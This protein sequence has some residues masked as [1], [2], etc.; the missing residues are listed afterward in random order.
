MNT[1]LV[2]PSVGPACVGAAPHQRKA[3]PRLRRPDRSKGL[4]PV[5]LEQLLEPAHPARLVW[6]F[7]QGLD[8]GTLYDS[9]KS[10]EGHPGRAPA[11]PRLLVALWLFATYDG[12]GSA[13][14]LARLCDP[15]RDGSLPYLW[16]CGGL[17]LNYHTLSDFRVKHADLLDRLLTDGLAV[18]LKEEL[19]E[20]EETAQD[21]LRVRASAGSGSFRRR[22]TLEQCQQQAHR[23]VEQLRAELEQDPAG[24]SRRQQAAR[25]RAARER[26]ERLG[27]A[28]QELAEL[29]RHKQ[30]R[31]EE[32][33]P[34]SDRSGPH[35]A[36]ASTT[37]PQAR[38]LRMADGGYRPAY[39]VELNTTTAGGVIVGVG[40]SNR[41]SDGGCVVAMLE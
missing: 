15:H 41:G 6:D 13:R 34:E 40:V 11:E 26:Q 35:E 17:A 16:L 24:P 27:R 4:P 33:G 37:D 39:N 10:V 9:I 29:E 25:R 12:V 7:A 28:L 5:P 31:Q 8:L 19:L 38:K 3:R 30:Q 23:R 2:N 36:R 1:T 32:R 14:R 22:R 21:S 20:L 18:M